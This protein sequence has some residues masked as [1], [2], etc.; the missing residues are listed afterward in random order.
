[1][2]YK[3]D[4]T[5]KISFPLG[6]IGTGS[7]GLAGNGSLID[8]EIYNKPNKKSING[9]SHFALKVKNKGET[10]VKVLQGDTIENLIGE[11][12]GKYYSGFGYGPRVGTM[13]GFPHFKNVK[14]NGTFPIANVSFSEENFPVKARL[15]AF[16]PFIPHDDYNSSLPCAFFEWELQNILDTEIE[17]ALAFSV[18]NPS[19]SSENIE[20]EENGF[21]GLNLVSAD[22]TVDKL[23]YSEL[24]I[25]TDGED[26]IVQESWYRGSWQD[27]IT[28]FWKDFSEK[29]R[30]PARSYRTEKNKEENSVIGNGNNEHGSVVSY[31]KIPKNSK[32]KLRFVLSWYVPNQYNYWSPLKDENGQD[33]TWKNYYATQF[34]SS[35]EV[36]FYAL[37]NFT[38][39]Y[40]KTKAF[41]DVLFRS[42]LPSSVIDAISSNL[43]VLKSPTVMR[44]E[45]GSLWGFEGCHEQAGS[46]DGS[47]QHVWNY[48]YA[49]CFLFPKLERS[50]R[51]N[52]IKYAMLPSGE[53]KFRIM[54]PVG[55]GYW[56]RRP[57]V[58]GQMGEIIKCYREWKIS[59]DD[60]WIKEYAPRIFKM[61]D[62]AW[63]PENADKWDEN[64][65]GVMEGRQHHTLDVELFGPSSWLQGFYLLALDCA[66]KIA[67]FVGDS[68]RSK[69][70]KEIYEKGRAW[71]NENL[72][73]GKYFFH[74]IDVK[75]KSIVEKYDA[76]SEERNFFSYWNEE[77]GEIKYQIADGCIIDQM[78]ADW[79]AYIIGEKGVFDA[80]KKKI[81]LKNLYKNNYKSSM[82]DVT[83][84]WR[85]FA[86]EDEAGTVICSYPEGTPV[87]AIPISYCEEC[88][89]G[90]EYAL[91]GLMLA[92]GYEKE[93]ETMVKAIR[94][95]YD[96]KLRNPWNEIECGSNYAR[97]MASFALL[98]IYSGFNFDMS[99]KYLGFNPLN[100][101]GEYLWSVGKTW[102]KVKTSKTSHKLSVLGEPI[103][104]SLYKTN[105]FKSV[106]KV[107]IDGKE[108]NFKRAD[109]GV[110]FSQA[111]VKKSLEIIF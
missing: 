23:G 101:Q 30:M 62:F 44:L 95:R 51:E 45:D 20:V 19:E 27:P 103:T 25:M 58:D 73:N 5:N 52:N 107:K 16:N 78:L 28:M 94:N 84:M 92:N 38:K 31:V 54:L 70:Y 64:K 80:D 106:S 108:T 111:K 15:T 9:Y 65:D 40:K 11:I 56:G 35:K 76:I 22:K 2:I 37:K 67:D 6:G 63:S 57:C 97:S 50:M 59:G 60:A 14:F 55:R 81:A 105:N 71:T 79:H 75:D 110:A 104:L 7:I 21:K 100:E 99:K 34:N 8:W 98:P 83:N 39:F 43:S 24:S 18:A 72:F 17:C 68:A 46:C 4:K 41:T 86:I 87:P 12:S 89:T 74:K 53:T 29:E 91:A 77:K 3:G 47:C 88:M 33:V 13:A 85:N 61:L 69:E 48:T 93:C 109:G 49:L 26:S 42:T 90:F 82:R 32:K 66:S 1:M 10:L 36:A 96:G 102:G